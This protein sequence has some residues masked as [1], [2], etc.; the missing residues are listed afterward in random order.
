MH[1]IDFL[2]QEIFR[3]ANTINSKV[4]YV[5]VTGHAIKIK[6]MVEKIRE[7]AQNLE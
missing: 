6:E 1:K 7:Q 4:P 5:G 2:S 3:E